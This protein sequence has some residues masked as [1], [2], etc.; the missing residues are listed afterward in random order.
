MPA[1]AHN[2][3][4]VCVHCITARSGDSEDDL[5]VIYN[6]FITV[7]DHG[8]LGQVSNLSPPLM[9]AEFPSEFDTHKWA[10]RPAG[11]KPNSVPYF[12][13]NANQDHVDDPLSHLGFAEGMSGRSFNFKTMMKPGFTPGP[14]S[15]SVPYILAYAAPVGDAELSS[16]SPTGAA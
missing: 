5:P 9:M 16:A 15:R 7:Y 2:F 10:V 14:G 11:A 8:D 4:C 13:V 6:Q 1:K 12:Y 3:K